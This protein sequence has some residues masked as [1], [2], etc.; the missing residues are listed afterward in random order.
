MDEN[1][2]KNYYIYGY[3]FF[4]IYRWDS[5]HN[6]MDGN[7]IVSKYKFSETF[8]INL[9]YLKRPLTVA[10]IEIENIKLIFCCVH[11]TAG[12]VSWK[13]REFEMKQIY[14]FF[15][16]KRFINSTIVLFGDF[17]F[18]YEFEEKNLKED[19]IDVWKKLKPN[20]DGYTFDSIDNLLIC[21]RTPIIPVKWQKRFDRILIKGEDIFPFSIDIWANQKIYKNN[22]EENQKSKKKINIFEYF[23]I[24]KWIY[25]IFRSLTSFFFDYLGINLWRTKHNY[26][27][28]SDHFGIVS[29]FKYNE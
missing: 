19:Y 7:I 21:E 25:Y 16:E 5:D 15:K 20:E 13:N 29:N 3:N 9:K 1:I 12:P 28:P 23:G 8:Q 17:N 22:N 24:I 26:L 11:L 10:I 4:K 6:T 27:F 2:N 18:V 14:E